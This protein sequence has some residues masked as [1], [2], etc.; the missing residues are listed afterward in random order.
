MFKSALGWGR[1]YSLSGREGKL[2]V[3]GGERSLYTL[4]AS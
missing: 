2:Y 4:L 1:D 3:T